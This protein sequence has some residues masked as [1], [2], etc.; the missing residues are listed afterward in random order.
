MVTV[1]D[2]F[3]LYRVLNCDHFCIY[4]DNVSVF[5]GPLYLI[6]E[7]VL[8]YVWNLEVLSSVIVGN[9]ATIR[10]TTNKNEEAKSP[11]ISLREVLKIV[12]DRGLV[13]IYDNE[14]HYITEF[15]PEKALTYLSGKVLNT[16]VER[17]CGKDIHAV[18]VYLKETEEEDL[19]T[20]EK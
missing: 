4:V 20:T 19:C 7:Q 11:V 16:P 13:Y 12:D 15:H 18:N 17:L 10:A 2:E 6:T 14:G 5:N 8:D 3:N 1:Q 9:I